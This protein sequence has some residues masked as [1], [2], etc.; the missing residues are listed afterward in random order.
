MNHDRWLELADVYA[1]GVLLYRL[2][3]GRLPFDGADAPFAEALRRLLDAEQ[4]PLGLTDADLRGPLERIVHRAMAR[5][6]AAR[7]PSAGALAAD[8]RAFCEG[9]SL[10]FDEPPRRP[11][12]SMA[13]HHRVLVASIVA[14][15]IAGALAAYAIL[16][17]LR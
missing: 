13:P 6:R 9:R 3:S 15:F 2:L 4:V 11:R 10:Q 1:I 16:A 8:L 7:Y 5:D 14:A 12:P 17:F